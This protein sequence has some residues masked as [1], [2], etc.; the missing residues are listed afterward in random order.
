[1]SP[2]QDSFSVFTPAVDVCYSNERG[3]L[4]SMRAAGVG[5]VGRPDDLGVRNE[6]GD[7]AAHDAYT[8]RNG[9]GGPHFLIATQPRRLVRHLLRGRGRKCEISRART[10]IA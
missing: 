10:G 5:A 8:L 9:S 6:L 7:P 3:K 2:R 4:R 1:M